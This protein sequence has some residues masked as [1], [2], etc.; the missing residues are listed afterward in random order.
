[1]RKDFCKVLAIMLLLTTANSSV[2]AW[3]PYT[4]IYTAELVRKEVANNGAVVING[5][6]Y[7]VNKDLTRALTR[8]PAYFN[9]G[10]VG[11]DGFPDITFGQAIIHPRHTGEW[12]QHVYTEA[13]QAQKEHRYT[14]DEKGQILAFTYGYLVHAAGDLWA[15]TLVNDIALGIFP[16]IVEIPKKPV[17]RDIAIRHMLVE[18]YVGDATPGFDGNP[19]RALLSNGDWSDDSTA[20]IEFAAPTKFIYYTLIDPD[21]STPSLCRNNLDDDED[22]ITDDGCGSIPQHGLT[23]ELS[24][25]PLIDF[26]LLLRT[27][28]RKS[29]NDLN[30]KRDIRDDSLDASIAAFEK[31]K[32]ACSPKS[33][34]ARGGKKCRPEWRAVKSLLGEHIGDEETLKVREVIEEMRRV[35][36]ALYLRW[37]ENR[38]DEGLK[39]WGEFALATTKA[40]FDPQARR[41]AQ[42]IECENKGRDRSTNQDKTRLK[43]ETNLK[44]S[45]VLYLESEKWVNT[46]LY[47]MLGLPKSTSNILKWIKGFDRWIDQKAVPFNPIREK[48]AGIDKWIKN[49]TN[50]FIKRR[51]GADVDAGEYL[52]KHP[53]AWLDVDQIKVPKMKHE[54]VLFA[55]GERQRLDGFMGFIGDDHLVPDEEAKPHSKFPHRVTRLDDEKGVFEPEK[56]AAIRNTI[57]STKLALL[58]GSTLNAVIKDVF[59]DRHVS[60]DGKNLE[61][62]SNVPHDYVPANFMIYSYKSSLANAHSNLWLRSIDSDHA[63][64]PDGLPRFVNQETP[65]PTPQCH[66]FRIGHPCPRSPNENGGNNTFPLWRSC[67]GRYVFRVL[68]H[69]W[70]NGAERFPDHGDYCEGTT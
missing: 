15:H 7:P 55:K 57:V 20:G 1:M 61:L 14:Y 28:I 48:K 68:F 22:G 53:A 24:R 32:N 69:D 10:V 27:K 63:W 16:S 8:W 43:C 36:L 65:L 42:N 37:W 70:E 64:R 59:R 58:D 25:G 40:L 51:T 46:H 35:L 47:A 9:A 41:N 3:K 4:H 50:D 19:D 2:Y 44:I 52:L 54:V 62:Y 45:T 33:V 5:H 67:V 17:L 26:F 66:P 12:L 38:I 31:F 23:S 11:P 29:R 39:S 49:A 6:Q 30:L 34:I 18:A 21:A 13:W 56:F 60:T